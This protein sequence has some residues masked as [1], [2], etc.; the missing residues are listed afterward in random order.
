MALPLPPGLTPPEVAFLCEMELVTV[1]PRQRLESLELLGGPTAALFP[2]HRSNI[3][4]WLALLLKRQ[5]RANISPPPWLTPTSLSAILEFEIE[6]SKEAFSPPPRLAPSAGSNNT[7]PPFLLSAT[8]DA[9]PEALPYHWLELGEI[10]LEAAPDDFEEPDQVRRLMRDLREVRTAK[11]RAGVAV[12][13]AGG[14]V[15]M[16][17]VGGME[18]AEGRAFIGGV[19][20]GLR[21]IGASREQARREREAE[22]RDN[23]YAGTAEDDEDEMD[24]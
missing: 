14:G 13:D 24:L 23:G 7:S 15:K 5:R 6:H 19:I 17:G 2:P 20:D 11:L 3:P 22:E 1:I 12:L 18:V 4:L 21:K 10:L 16:N 8:S 9:P